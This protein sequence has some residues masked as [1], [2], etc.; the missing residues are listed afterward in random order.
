LNPK[1]KQNQ[2]TKKH[3]IG[4][5]NLGEKTMNEDVY[6]KETLEKLYALREKKAKEKPKEKPK[7]EKAERKKM[8]KNSL[9]DDLEGRKIRVYMMDGKVFEG[10][11]K[12]VAIYDFILNVDGKDLLMFKHS[13]NYIE[14]IG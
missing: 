3:R 1:A 12:E 6:T 13:I 14:Y 2:K 4:I 10:I 8:I 7:E 9:V 11:V 5:T